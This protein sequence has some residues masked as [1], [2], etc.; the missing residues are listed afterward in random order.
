MPHLELYKTIVRVVNGGSVLLD[1][2][3]SPNIS[4]ASIAKK[5][6]K[7]GTKISKAIGSFDVRGEAIKID[8]NLKHIPIGLLNNAVLKRDISKGE[9]IQFDDIDIDD[10]LCIDVWHKILS[11]RKIK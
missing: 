10:D 4:V 6:L 7:S 11:S 5:D 9:V 1:N 3:S 2:S 8:D